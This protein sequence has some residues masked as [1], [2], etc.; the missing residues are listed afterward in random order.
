[1]RLSSCQSVFSASS[2]FLIYFSSSS[3]Y[4]FQ[5]S[6]A[7]HADTILHEDHNHH[8]LPSL[9][10]EPDTSQNRQ[11]REGNYEPDFLGLNKGIVGR[12][13]EDFTPLA[14]N[15]PLP[16][17]IKPGDIQYWSF[18]KT[19]LRDPRVRP[20]LD[21]P[22]NLTTS[23]T[24]CLEEDLNQLAATQR[25]T[26][27][28]RTVWLTLSI[29]DRPTSTTAG[30]T[31][32]PPQLEAFVSRSSSNKRPDSGRSDQIIAVTDGYGNLTLSSVTD[33]LWIG[34]KAPQQLNGFDGSYSYELVASVDAPYATYFD[35]N[36]KFNSTEITAWDTDSNSAILWTGDITNAL[37]NWTVF[38][39]WM[40]KKPPPFQIYV[41]DETDPV[42]GGIS[43][44]VCGLK[45]H[46]K[47]KDSNNTMIRIGGQPKQQFYVTDLNSS[48]SYM[49]TM[50]LE[51]KSS[52]LTV[53]G[54]G[55][56]W[57]ATNFTT[58]SGMSKILYLLHLIVPAANAIYQTPLAR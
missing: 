33:D 58:K 57:R 54:G 2:I 55:T 11:I 7:S 45:K 50:T 51:S 29:C 53:G 10:G 30:N 26:P 1:M 18:P 8:R 19:I 37:S 39:E 48:S 52:N 36:P 42:V 6:Q 3:T 22:L 28:T 4:L 32:A 21:V 5:L 56:V 40:E 9:F 46:A 23:N 16:M 14:N 31:L 35:L 43:R 12:A 13:A 24:T 20:T 27:S 38:S 47:V 44:S 34:V 17:D 25:M 15:A 41:Y 49:A